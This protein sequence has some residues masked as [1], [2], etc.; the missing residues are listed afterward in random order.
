MSTTTRSDDA[1]SVH[2]FPDGTAARLRPLGAGETHLVQDVFDQ[3][4]ERSRFLR[5]HVPTPRLTLAARR[6]LATVDGLERSAVVALSGR[7]AVGMAHWAR[8][9][10][11]PTVAELAVAVADRY[12]RGG[13]GRA[14]V[15]AAATDAASVGVTHVACV[16]HPENHRVV[17]AL[18]RLGAVP[19]PDESDESDELILRVRALA[20][21]GHRREES[22]RGTMATWSTAFWARF[23]WSATGTT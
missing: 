8:Y 5:F 13:L 6:R 1:G 10:E 11:D 16:V 21:I 7:R 22:G 4:S 19:R 3:L 2:R 20:G 18:R 12:Q 9:G 17:R 15:A 23:G 14:L